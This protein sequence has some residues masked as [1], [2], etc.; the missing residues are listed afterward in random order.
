MSQGCEKRIPTH[1]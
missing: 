1:L